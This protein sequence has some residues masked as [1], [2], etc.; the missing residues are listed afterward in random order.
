MILLAFLMGMKIGAARFRAKGINP[1]CIYDIGLIAMVSGVLG[2]RLFHLVQFR[3]QFD[4]ALFS[5]S[6]GV[7]LAGAMVGLLLLV[8]CYR[9]PQAMTYL[10]MGL[11]ALILIKHQHLLATPPGTFHIFDLL[12]LLITVYFAGK[13]LRPLWSYVKQASRGQ[14]TLFFSTAIACT[15]VGMR[16]I[17]CYQFAANYSWDAFMIWRGGLVFFG[18]FILATICLMYFFKKKNLPMLKISDLL[19]PTLALGLAITRIGCF[20]NGC[21]FGATCPMDAPYGVHFPAHSLAGQSQNL[22]GLNV[23]Y[24]WKAYAPKTLHYL[25][26]LP[27]GH[28]EITRQLPKYLPP[29]LYRAIFKPVYP[30][31]L[32]A[33]LS[34]FALF[35]F[36]L[37]F[38]R[39][40]RH[41]GEALLMFGIV[42]GIFRFMEEMMRSDTAAVLGALTISQ[43]V[44]CVLFCLCGG[45]FI[46]LRLR[47]SWQQRNQ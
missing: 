2:A 8:A 41:D 33:S 23:E 37:W 44:S 38:D 10:G 46:F 40:R 31:Q 19:T 24:L 12:F 47:S 14:Q 39:Y 5:L 9:Q 15:I 45:I 17:Y 4:W 18:G 16:G 32:F 7:S 1:E 3:Q 42:Y 35:L 11:V 36:L 13:N 27:G 26:K 28:Y 34:G 30:S 25:A 43:V 21:C 29:D 20:L 22:R 6:D